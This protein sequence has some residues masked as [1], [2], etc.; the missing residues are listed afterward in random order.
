MGSSPTLGEVFYAMNP[1]DW[2]KLMR[3][4]FDAQALV[5]NYFSLQYTLLK[6]NIQPIPIS[7]RE[8]VSASGNAAVSI[9][10]DYFC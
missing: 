7:V 2:G 4:D 6:D 8:A 9:E 5:R 3:V 10:H 1:M